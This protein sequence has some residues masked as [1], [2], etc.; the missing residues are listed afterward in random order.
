[1]RLTQ[2]EVIDTLQH[3]VIFG[4]VPREAMAEMIPHIEELEVRT[5][6]AIIKEGDHGDH[7]YVIARGSVRVDQD[8]RTLRELGQYDVFGEWAVLH[9]TLRVA[10]VLAIEDSLLLQVAGKPFLELIRSWPEAMLGVISEY[11]TRL[12]TYMHDLSTL[13][14][15]LEE[16]ILPLGIA[17]ASEDNADK[18]MERIL[19]EAMRLCSADSGIFYLRTEDSTL[20]YAV[21]QIHSQNLVLGGA[22]GTE[23]PYP[24]LALDGNEAVK[25]VA[26]HVALNG[27]TINVPDIYADEG[28]DFSETKARDAE[29]GYRSES[30]LAVALRDQSGEVIG[31][32]QLVNAQDPQ[33]GKITPFGAFL[34]L[35]IESLTA[36]AAVALNS[37]VLLHREQEYI[38]LEQDVHVARRIQAGFLPRTLPQVEGWEIAA[39]FQPARE[40]AGDWYD[41]FMMTQGRRIGF[42]IADV[43]DKGVP[44][45]LFMALVR[46]LTRAFAQQNYSVDWSSMLGEGGKGRRGQSRSQSR[47]RAMP[48]A[49]TMSLYN[50]VVL[51]NNYILDNHADDNMFATLFFG[52]LNPDTGQLLYINAGHNPPFI[53]GADGTLKAS[54]PNSGA[55]V[56]MFPNIDYQIEEAM[57]EPGDVLYT[58]TDGVTEARNAAGEFLTEPGLLDLLN[59][60]VTSA[61]SLL[62][63]IQTYLAG[64]MRGAVQADDITMLAVR[65]EL[66]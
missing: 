35:M 48:S 51:A 22:S 28:F 21:M 17:L 46:S 40:V 27:R 60:P 33:T 24:P 42:V 23:I 43:V 61:A 64:F 8:R 44:A 50:A 57:L 49:G 39:S 12:L 16:V 37:Q 6:Q 63:K 54:L 13:R 26:V 52:M 19:A 10:S 15:Q 38:K 25:N 9:S 18:L 20:A 41:A 3:T 5:G 34:Q 53:L 1:M 2:D 7:L 29:L 45:A 62:D 36:Q 4:G 30:C 66:Q 14:D 56:G 11:N 59:A 32:L 58:Y 55:A 47:M 65:R 31:V